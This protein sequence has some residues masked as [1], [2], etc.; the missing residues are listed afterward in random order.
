MFLQANEDTLTLFYPDALGKPITFIDSDLEERINSSLA[1][2][3]WIGQSGSE[4]FLNKIRVTASLKHGLLKFGYLRN[5]IIVSTKS[6]MYATMSWSRFGHDLCRV[7]RLITQEARRNALAEM[8]SMPYQ[9]LCVYINLGSAACTTGL[10]PTCRCMLDGQCADGKLTLYLNNTAFYSSPQNREDFLGS[11][12]KALSK[13]D[14]TCGGMPFYPAPNNFSHGKPC[15]SIG[16]CAPTVLPPCTPGKDCYCCVNTSHVCSIDKDCNRFDIGSMCGCRPEKNG[17]GVCGPF[18]DPD[19][20]V[21]TD[22]VRLGKEATSTLLPA[23]KGVSCVYAGPGS[24]TCRSA[25]YVV[26]GSSLPTLVEGVS[27]GSLGSSYVQMYGTLVDVNRALESMHY[28]TD[29]DYNRL[30]RPPES[31]RDPLTFNIE[32]DTLETLTIVANDMGNSGGGKYDPQESIRTV[33]VRVVAVN[34]KPSANGPPVVRACPLC[35]TPFVRCGRCKS[36][37]IFVQIPC[38]DRLHLH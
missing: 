38:E 23:F 16:D 24:D 33:N 5:L 8:K 11:L 30:W 17:G 34:D 31:E 22:L 18:I 29:V 25:A 7:S 26:E 28:V 20:T 14:R 1:Y 37:D 13:L 10:Q 36:T 35:C 12:K 21:T 3:N 15:S 19:G 32:T 9:E 6:T 2:K 27:K 4:V